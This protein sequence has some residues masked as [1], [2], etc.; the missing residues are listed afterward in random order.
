MKL[1]RIGAEDIDNHSALLSACFSNDSVECVVLTDQG[2]D[3]NIMPPNVLETIIRTAASL[4]ILNLGQPVSFSGVD[5]NT[6]IRC[7]QELTIDI[8]LRVRHGS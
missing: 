8:S 4:K 3:G 7:T 1:Q 2:A 5:G 6:V